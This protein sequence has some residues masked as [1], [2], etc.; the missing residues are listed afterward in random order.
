VSTAGRSCICQFSP[1]RRQQHALDLTLLTSCLLLCVQPGPRTEFA[2]DDF[3]PFVPPFPATPQTPAPPPQPLASLTPD[4]LFV[5]P[6]DCG[7][8]PCTPARLCLMRI[9]V[10]PR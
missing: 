5:R 8:T 7:R 6:S 2:F 3:P 10:T 1:R 4:A 9:D